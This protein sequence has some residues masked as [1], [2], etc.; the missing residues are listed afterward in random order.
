M[1]PRVAIIG[2]GRIGAESSKRFIGLIPDGYLP[3]SHAE[4]IKSIDRLE[5][6]AICDQNLELLRQQQYFYNVKNIFTDYK[7]LIDNIRPDIIS[8]ATRTD[9][10]CDIIDYALD[11]GVKGIYAE[12]PFSRSVKR[13]KQILEKVQAC[14]AKITFGT[15]RRANEIY[16]KAKDIIKAGEIGDIVHI[17]VEYGMKPLFWTFPHMIDLMIFFANNTEP[18]FV[19]AYSSS[20]ISEVSEN[21]IDLDPIVDNCYFRF[22]NGVTASSSPAETFNTNIYGKKGYIIVQGDGMYIQV[23]KQGKIPLYFHD[24]ETYNVNATM[25]GTQH[26]FEDLSDAVLNDKPIMHISPLEILANQR[27][28]SGIAQSAIN[29][30]Q[31]L[32]FKDLNEEL[33]ITGRSGGMFA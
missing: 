6:V 33:V 11:K 8:V 15:T 4:S 30:G 1:K 23:Y 26:L 16:R 29:K 25:S 3:I 31:V 32:D 24:L 28:L 12:K 13:C 17:N 20:L 7:E 14:N 27:M 22:S 18:E 21:I 9:V 2:T 19:H 5:L 10:R